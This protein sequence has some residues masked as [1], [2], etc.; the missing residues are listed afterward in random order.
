MLA[1]RRLPA[2]AVRVVEAVALA[3]TTALLAS[4]SKAAALA[5]LVHWVGNPV[6]AGITTNG[7]VVRVHTDDLKVLV[8]TVLVHPVR[9]EDAQVRHLATDTLLSKH[10]KR[11]LRLELV[12]TLVNRL[13]VGSALANVL[14]TVTTAN[15]HTV[16]NIAL[17]SFVS[18]AASLVRTRR[19]R[20]AV[21]NVELAVFPAAGKC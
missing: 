21:H 14:L 5:V 18:K 3:D 6:D 8:D 2:T 16:D 20:R 9:V 17:L 10:T 7:L 19:T 15:T 4:S 12:H 1:V 13:A 11:A